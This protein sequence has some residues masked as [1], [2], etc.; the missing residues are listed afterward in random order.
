MGA[1]LSKFN[2]IFKNSVMLP[3]ATGLFAKMYTVHC[4]DA[5][6]CH[7]T[8]CRHRLFAIRFQQHHKHTKRKSH[9]RTNGHGLSFYSILLTPTTTSH[10]LAVAGIRGTLS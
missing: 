4:F 10:R 6:S 8:S 9:D 2:E 3:H 1:C 5:P 7:R